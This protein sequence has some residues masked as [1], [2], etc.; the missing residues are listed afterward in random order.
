MFTA[1]ALGRGLMDIDMKR[2]E[3]MQGGRNLE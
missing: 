3:S 2:S 1:F